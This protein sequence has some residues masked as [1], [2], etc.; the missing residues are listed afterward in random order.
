MVI[1]EHSSPDIPPFPNIWATP[2]SL[3]QAGEAAGQKV[4]IA[5]AHFLSLCFKKGTL[6]FGG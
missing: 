4:E 2:S 6:E 3:F 1:L 5:N